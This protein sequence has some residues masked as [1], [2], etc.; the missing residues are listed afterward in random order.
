[1]LDVIRELR[2]GIREVGGIGMVE[3]SDIQRLI[4]NGNDQVTPDIKKKTT[5]K[6]KGG[7]SKGGWMHPKGFMVMTPT[8]HG[9]VKG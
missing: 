4:S 9:S 8:G 3:T 6:Y 5:K 1:M 7:K 2:S